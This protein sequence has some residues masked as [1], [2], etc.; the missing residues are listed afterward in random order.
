V[1]IL[2]FIDSAASFGL[3]HLIWAPTGSY[4]V[5]GGFLQV[6]WSGAFSLGSAA[7]MLKIVRR[8]N[9][10]FEDIFFRF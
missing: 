10:D 8:S 6:L 2:S 3:I 1:G 5:N 4:R 9:P 7:F